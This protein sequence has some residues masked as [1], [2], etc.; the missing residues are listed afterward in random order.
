M[1]A[2]YEHDAYG[3][4]QTLHLFD[5]MLAASLYVQRK[6]ELTS[7]EQ[8]EILE[9]QE[10]CIVPKNGKNISYG[11]L[12]EF[13]EVDANMDDVVFYDTLYIDDHRKKQ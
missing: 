8:T 12:V 9:E 5:K 13:E 6:H 1:I 3:E 2:L 11:K 10:A 7:Q 4:H